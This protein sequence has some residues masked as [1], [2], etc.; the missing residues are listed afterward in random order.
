MTVEGA[1]VAWADVSQGSGGPF[2]GLYLGSVVVILSFFFLSFIF[3]RYD[4]INSDFII[5]DQ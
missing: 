4:L 5:L 2:V 3:C 1:V